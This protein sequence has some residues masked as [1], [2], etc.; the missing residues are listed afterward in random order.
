[1]KSS[2]ARCVPVPAPVCANPIWPGFAFATAMSSL[3][4]LT[5][6]GF[7]I[8]MYGCFATSTTGAKSFTGS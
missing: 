1:M 7:A 6:E 8:S 5:D 2:P 3:T 4:E